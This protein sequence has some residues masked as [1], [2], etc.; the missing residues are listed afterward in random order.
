[1]FNC[2]P[3]L[4]IHITELFSIVLTSFFIFLYYLIVSTVKLSNNDYRD[5]LMTISCSFITFFQVAHN[6]MLIDYK[7]NI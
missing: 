1:M 2:K 4:T 3:G 5:K 6:V 7:M